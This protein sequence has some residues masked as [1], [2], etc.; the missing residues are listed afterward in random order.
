M[1]KPDVSSIHERVAVDSPRSSPSLKAVTL[2]SPKPV[3]APDTG[4]SSSLVSTDSS[5]S[6]DVDAQVEG[7][8]INTSNTQKPPLEPNEPAKLNLFTT[9]PGSKTRP[10]PEGILWVTV[11]MIGLFDIDS[12]F[13]SMSNA[14]LLRNVGV[15]G[16]GVGGGVMAH[17]DA[18]PT[19]SL[20]AM[21]MRA[22]EFILLQ[23]CIAS[24]AYMLP[25]E[26]A[27]SFPVFYLPAS[28]LAVDLTLQPNE[29]ATCMCFYFSTST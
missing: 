10:A 4:T 1:P 27:K 15:I 18:A 24:S 20:E 25:L 9:S 21:T 13:I 7:V 5:S 28:M 12:N 29:I 11:K 2:D 19:S 26:N 8:A 22:G 6:L 14:E 16:A 3:R 17:P 23:L